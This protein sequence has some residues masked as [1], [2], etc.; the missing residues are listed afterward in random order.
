M[1]KRLLSFMVE[2][3]KFILMKDSKNKPLALEFLLESSDIFYKK[4]DWDCYGYCLRFL[5]SDEA[6]RSYMDLI[7]YKKI[8]IDIEGKS[9]FG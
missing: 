7:K 3:S 6:L 8:F 9:F 2:L 4:E 5:G 1:K